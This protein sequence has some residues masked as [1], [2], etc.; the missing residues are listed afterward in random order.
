MWP[1]KGQVLISHNTELYHI[2]TSHF[3]RT[4][5]R[6]VTFAICRRK[7]V[8]SLSVTFV[9]HTRRAK[10]SSNIFAPTNSLGTRTVC[11]KI[12]ERNLKAVLGD[13]AW[14]GY[15]KMTFFDQHIDLVQK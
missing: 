1:L 8:C 4:L 5:L 3:E 6:Y 9:Q 7:S 11:V 14:K 2:H 10:R 15:E 12:L 13:R